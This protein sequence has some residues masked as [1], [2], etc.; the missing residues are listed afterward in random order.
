MDQTIAA[1]CPEFNE[2]ISVR[3]CNGAD[4][5]LACDLGTPCGKDIKRLIDKAREV[6]I[7][8]AY[9]P[10]FWRAIFGSACVFYYD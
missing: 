5:M 4:D 10:L 9:A 6:P 2:Y 1:Y 8:S 3:S 7:D